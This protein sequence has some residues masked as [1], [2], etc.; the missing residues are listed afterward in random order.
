[1]HAAEQTLSLEGHE[2]LTAFLLGDY[3]VTI[4]E[5][6]DTINQKVTPEL[7]VRFEEDPHSKSVQRGVWEGAPRLTSWAPQLTLRH[8]LYNYF[9]EENEH[10][11]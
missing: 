7:I 6:I 11:I 1:L 8:G 10:Y 2:E 5:L 9:M 4:E 3:T